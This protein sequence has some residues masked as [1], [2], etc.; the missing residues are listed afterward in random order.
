MLR[1]EGQVMT[2]MLGVA[3][4]VAVTVLL[5]TCAN[6]EQTPARQTADRLIA[7]VNS[8]DTTAL[9]GVF[10]DSALHLMTIEQ[11]LATRGD[12][13]M[14]FGNLRRV[15]GPSF[16][17][18]SSATVVLR[19]AEMSL[20][21]SLE[22]APDGRIRYLAIQPEPVLRSVETP[23][24]DNVQDVTDIAVLRHAFNADSGYVRAV[25]LLSPT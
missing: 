4:L 22:F 9:R 1:A 24:A 23:G 10:T 21:A 3:A 7:F 14:Q 17:N 16:Q 2:R 25:T 11:M 5:T 15:D 19:Y 6:Q 12:F 18:D 20:M 8:G 13:L